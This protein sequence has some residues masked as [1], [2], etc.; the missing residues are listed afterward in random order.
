VDEP[1]EA[2]SREKMEMTKDFFAM[3][4]FECPSN[5]EKVIGLGET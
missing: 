5:G 2:Q 4:R 1:G 3:A